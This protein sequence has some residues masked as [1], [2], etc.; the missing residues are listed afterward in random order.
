[1]TS[2]ETQADTGD[3]LGGIDAKNERAIV[4]G[5]DMESNSP[6]SPQYRSLK[7]AIYPGEIRGSIERT[8]EASGTQ[9][10]AKT[11]TDA[12]TKSMTPLDN[13]V[14][15]GVA[16]MEVTPVHAEAPLALASDSHAVG[17]ADTCASKTV[18]PW[19]I[20]THALPLADV[21]LDTLPGYTQGL[22]ALASWRVIPPGSREPQPAITVGMVE[23][24]NTAVVAFFARVLRKP[25]GAVQAALI[26]T[27]CMA[28]ACRGAQQPETII[29]A[30]AYR[31]HRLTTGTIV[32]YIPLVATDDAPATF[33]GLVGP[34][35]GSEV[36]GCTT[37][38]G[39]GLWR[40]LMQQ[41]KD[42]A[43]EL[44]QGERY[45]VEVQPKATYSAWFKNV[46]GFEP[47]A[48]LECA[49]P[50]R[51]CEMLRWPALGDEATRQ[52]YDTYGDNDLVA[53]ARAGYVA[54]TLSAGSVASIDALLALTPQS[55]VLWIGT[56]KGPELLAMAR[57]YPE[58]QFI[59]LEWCEVAT[60]AVE[61]KRAQ[62]GIGNVTLYMGDLGSVSSTWKAAGEPG[63]ST[64]MPVPRKQC[65]H[66]FSTVI[67][68]DWYEWL[69]DTARGSRLC[70]LE[71]PELVERLRAQSTAVGASVVQSRRV[72]VQGSGEQRRLLAGDVPLHARMSRGHAHFDK[73]SHLPKWAGHATHAATSS[74]GVP[75]GAPTALPIGFAVAAPPSR[76]YF[77]SFAH[78][79]GS[80]SHPAKSNAHT[81]KLEIPGSTAVTGAGAVAG[82]AASYGSLSSTTHP[83][84]SRGTT[85]TCSPSS[86]ETPGI[87]AP[88][89]APADDLYRERLQLLAE[90]RRATAPDCDVQHTPGEF[91]DND[92]IYNEQKLKVGT[93][94]TK[95]MHDGYNVIGCNERGCQCPRVTFVAAST[96]AKIVRGGD[97]KPF[98]NAMLKTRR[99]CP[100]WRASNKDTTIVV[101]PIEA[102]QMIAEFESEVLAERRRHNKLSFT[103]TDP[104][105]LGLHLQ[106]DHEG[107]RV[108]KF[109]ILGLVLEG[110][111]SKVVEEAV[112]RAWT[113]AA[114]AVR[115]R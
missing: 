57:K 3:G 111:V 61:Q 26:S 41:C 62:L 83:C 35:P 6:T 101:P 16:H 8:R 70:A 42:K 74:T 79:P 64:S 93:F 7:P 109:K 5:Q 69:F 47:V 58:C 51:E 82:G 75:P 43:I 67:G 4:V 99:Y 49:E 33:D 25:E 44:A 104:A 105:S 106:I 113:A 18:S 10:V 108:Q 96:V 36:L 1:M 2:T 14:P 12:H 77:A 110:Q 50:L 87:G 31:M 52:V 23:P 39:R 55:T 68:D 65:T 98:G 85:G 45:F 97:R 46:C 28:I 32:L 34:P 100:T 78:A 22:H 56:S 84:A 88:L 11:D 72:W 103:F 66:V 73:L 29:A 94:F 90:K 38:T 59:G 76:E 40:L 54:V 112:R 115:A 91:T 17:A 53:V 30:L 114:L 20:L 19:C 63:Q 13:A 102:T 21:S 107:G 71:T 81:P 15:S 92:I 80:N 95:Q 89:S 37:W 9:A 24:S 27:Q 48:G 60:A 86:G